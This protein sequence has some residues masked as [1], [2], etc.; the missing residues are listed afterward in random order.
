MNDEKREGQSPDGEGG[1]SIRDIFRIIGKKIWYVLGGSLLVTLA[2]VL[3]FMFAI[4]PFLLSNSMSFRID[5]PMYSEGKFPDGSAF[6][7]SSI[8]SREVIEEAKK[9]KSEFASINT[10]GL[11]KNEGISISAQRNG[12]GNSY[13]YTLSLKKSYFRGVDAMDFIKA[14]TDTFKS[15]VIVGQKVEGS[16]DFKLDEANFDGETF[17]G[18]LSLLSEQ[19]AIILKEYDAWI[20]CYSAG[21]IV[22]GK[23]LSNHRADVASILSD[24]EQASIE[25]TLSF[26]GYGYFKSSVTDKDVEARIAWLER[27]LVSAKASLEELRQSY[28]GASP[29]MLA[30]V[31]TAK[32]IDAEDASGGIVISPEASLSQRL[33]YYS[34]RVSLLELQKTNLESKSSAQMAADIAAF[35]A[36][37]LKGKLAKL[38]EKAE[39]LKTVISAIYTKDTVVMFNSQKVEKSGGTSLVI[40]GI[41]VFVVAFLV[42]CVIAYY[43]GRK[44][45]KRPKVE[46]QPPQPEESDQNE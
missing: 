22:S 27:E 1:V 25:S 13:I 20:S 37:Y 38:N 24:D 42:L 12:D 16:I 21:R 14:L 32:S 7:Y 9:Q 45:A 8:I 39:L 26:H 11:L 30:D 40:V 15:Y 41:G 23:S 33:A 17:Q 5:Y 29:A 46:K 28:S 19:K 34:E 6:D 44:G 10:T 4:N 43:R 18:Q 3:I 2:A 35:G 31:Y 36:Q